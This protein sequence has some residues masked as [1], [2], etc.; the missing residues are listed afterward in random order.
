MQSKFEW[1]EGDF[2]LYS[3]SAGIAGIT[4][5]VITNPFWLVRTRM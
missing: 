2:Y 3:F 5:N 1:H 4:C